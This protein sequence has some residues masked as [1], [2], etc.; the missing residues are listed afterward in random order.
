MCSPVAGSSSPVDR[1]SPTSWKPTGTCVS[2]VQ[3][4]RSDGAA[5]TDQ[6]TGEVTADGALAPG[7]AAGDVPEE[8][9]TSRL[10]TTLPGTPIEPASQTGVDAGLNAVALDR[11]RADFPILE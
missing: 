4:Q 11:I 10:D 6:L 9:D 7:P 2:P 8:V 3:R 5:I 1:N